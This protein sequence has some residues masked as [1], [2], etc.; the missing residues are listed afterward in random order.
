MLEYLSVRGF[1]IWLLV[2]SY[3]N[4]KNGNYIF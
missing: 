2:F 3:K 4:D 1:I